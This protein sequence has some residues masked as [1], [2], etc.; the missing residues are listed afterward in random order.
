M[1]NCGEVCTHGNST[2]VSG[3]RLRG[4]GGSG[5]GA[6]THGN[7]TKVRPHRYANG[8]RRRRVPRIRGFRIYVSV[9]EHLPTGIR[10]WSRISGPRSRIPGFRFRV[11]GCRVPDSG[12]QSFGFR[13]VGCRVFRSTYP[14]ELDDGQAPEVG[15][16]MVHSRCD[17]LVVHH[18]FA[19]R[20]GVQGFVFCFLGFRDQGSGLRV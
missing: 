8:W 1:G 17:F 7:S 16:R 19:F 12:F 18:L 6:L 4:F 14:R 3:F 9:G 13:V 5:S 11:V 20:F 15:E 2:M 10:P